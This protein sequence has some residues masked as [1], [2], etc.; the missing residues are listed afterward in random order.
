MSFPVLVAHQVY[1]HFFNLGGRLAPVSIRDQM[2]RA[3]AFVDDAVAAGLIGSQPWRPL[4][5]VGAGAAGATAACWAAVHH[6]IPTLLVE[7]DSAAFNRQANCT[8][9]WIDPT[10]YDWPAGHWTRAVCP[11]EPM[12][13]P[14]PWPADF[15]NLLATRWKVQLSAARRSRWYAAAFNTVVSHA[16]QVFSAG[17]PIGWNVALRG[18]LNTTIQVATI[19]WTVGYGTERCNFGNYVGYPFW[20]TDPFAQAGCGV[21]GGE[22]DVVISG[23]GDGALQDLLRIT[24]TLDSAEAV[25]KNC[26]LSASQCSTI[27]RDLHSAEDLAQRLFHWGPGQRAGATVRNDH[28]TLRTLHQ[29]HKRLAMAVL[30]KPGSRV[31][32]ELDG[33]IRHNLPRI[34]LIHSCDHF[35]NAYA[36]NRFLALLVGEFLKTQRGQDI[37][38]PRRRIAAI[39]HRGCAPPPANPR[40]WSHCHGQI[41]DIDLE[42]L[43]DCRYPPGKAGSAETLTANVLIIRHGINTAAIP[44]LP[45]VTISGNTMPPLPDIA[46]TRQIIPY[47]VLT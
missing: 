22:P 20:E 3:Q 39:R 6:R 25:L 38:V 32:D 18:K 27:E 47:H 29:A 33:L 7:R 40:P 44:S 17:R 1:P 45:T 21:S 30:N 34:R 36:L 19:L 8:T 14:M 2:V 35:S 24:T 9:R 43:N 12:P 4:L 41:H 13:T 26:G 23:S 15:S 42:Q 31:P 28:D 46:L 11:S 5:I 16:S 10:Q 37:F